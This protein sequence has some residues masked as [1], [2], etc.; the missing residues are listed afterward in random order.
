VENKKSY[1]DQKAEGDKMSKIFS[2]ER[3]L[4]YLHHFNKV[5]QKNGEDSKK[6]IAGG[7]HV[8]YADFALFHVLDATAVQFNSDFY[9]KA[10]DNAKVPELN[11]YYEWM[12]AR[13]NLQAYFASDR[14]KRTIL[15]CILSLKR[16][17]F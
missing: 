6:P 13:P 1:N 14:C 2:Q 16:F 10:W 7:T 9:E 4:M 11:E 15:F 17:P 5:V 12:K 8:T 3:M